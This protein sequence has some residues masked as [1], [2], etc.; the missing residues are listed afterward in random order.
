MKLKGLKFK[1]ILNILKKNLPLIL[2]VLILIVVTVVSIK[3]GKYI[4]SND[5]YSPELNPALQ[6]LGI[7]SL[8]HGEDTEY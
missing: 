5:N 1:N 6:Y 7:C 3:P 2:L 4:L 8:L